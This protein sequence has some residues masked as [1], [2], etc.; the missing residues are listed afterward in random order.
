[1][2]SSLKAIFTVIDDIP[3]ITPVG[4][5]IPCFKDLY[6]ADKSSGK[7][8]YADLLGYIY[9][10]SAYE[11]PFYNAKNKGEIVADKFLGN[12]NYKPTKLVEACIKECIDRESVPERRTL[13][14]AIILCDSISDQVK[15]SENNKKNYER[16]MKDIESELDKEKSLSRRL[17]LYKAKQDLEKTALATAVTSANLVESLKKQTTHLVELRKI[18]DAATKEFDSQENPNAIS[19][20]FIDQF[21]NE[22]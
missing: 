6:L 8:T 15:A 4:I 10:M 14:A 11:S 21:V 22:Y 17:D 13:D 16:L 19:V 12:P 5:N 3:S 7:T 2:A 20:A 1:M 18:V 9:H